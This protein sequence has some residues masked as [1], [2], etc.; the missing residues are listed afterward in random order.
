[1][2][3]IGIGF[4]GLVLSG[5]S[6]AS[7]SEPPR[8]APLATCAG[9]GT[10]LATVGALGIGIGATMRSD[11]RVGIVGLPGA[12]LAA[13][14][15]PMA[16]VCS[17]RRASV[18]GVSPLAAQAAL[19][20]LGLAAV[21][22][23]AA[24]PMW[25]G[26]Y[27][28]SSRGYQISRWTLNHTTHLWVVTSLTLAISQGVM[29]RRP[30]ANDTHR[31]SSVALNVV[32]GTGVAMGVAGIVLTTVG[33]VGVNRWNDAITDGT[34]FIGTFHPYRELWIPG[35][36][37]GGL[38]SVTAAGSSFGQARRLGRHG[39]LSV[40]AGVL[41]LASGG[42]A[43]AVADDDFAMEWITMVSMPLQAS[44]LTLS[45]VEAGRG[46]GTQ[47]QARIYPTIGGAVVRGRW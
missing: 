24:W 5:S 16:G 25:S 18:R 27:M 9:I 21:S 43:V 12:G 2:R 1:M 40:A 4:L 23:G 30:K 28:D 31:R 26:H 22:A 10:A 11:T 17:W 29:N 13:I 36:V 34:T 32:T 20:A 33:T 46:S 39:S 38:G 15:L 3:S 44:A 7:A 37:I 41:A 8:V 19:G 42:F 14:G 47:V 6:A 45:A 35:L